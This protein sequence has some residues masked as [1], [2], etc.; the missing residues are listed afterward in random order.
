MTTV[1]N[2]NNMSTEYNLTHFAHSTHPIPNHVALANSHIIYS[3]YYTS[4]IIYPII[5]SNGK[6]NNFYKPIG[7]I[8][9]NSSNSEKE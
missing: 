6:S 7:S 4:T 5:P 9:Q 3:N 8:I 2:P 1:L